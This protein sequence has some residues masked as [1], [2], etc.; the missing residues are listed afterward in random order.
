[1]DELI[2]KSNLKIVVEALMLLMDK[3]SQSMAEQDTKIEELRD[4]IGSP[5]QYVEQELTDAQKVQTRKNLDLY[6][7]RTTE[8]TWDGVIDGLDC[9]GDERDGYYRISS[10][11]IPRT[12][13]DGYAVE[14]INVDG[15]VQTTVCT[16]R[17]LWGNDEVY[18]PVTFFVVTRDGARLSDITFPLKGIYFYRAAD[19]GV[20]GYV[21]K[22]YKEEKETIPEWALPDID[23]DALSVQV[24]NTDG[25]MTEHDLLYLERGI[26]IIGES[27]D[28][29]GWHNELR[30]IVTCKTIPYCPYYADYED[31]GGLLTPM[32]GGVD[33]NDK[34]QFEWALNPNREWMGI[35]KLGAG[36]RLG[37]QIQSINE[38]GEMTAAPELLVLDNG[39]YHIVEPMLVE[40]MKP[41]YEGQYES[42]EI[43][44]LIYIDNGTI[45]SFAHG[46]IFCDYNESNGRFD[47]MYPLDGCG[48]Y[49]YDE[50][51]QE[52]EQKQSTL[53]PNGGAQVGQIIQIAEVDEDGRP[54]AW[55][56]V[57]IPEPGNS[58]YVVGITTDPDTSANVADKTF[59]E[60]STEFVEN[61]NIVAT[62]RGA[63]YNCVYARADGILFVKTECFKASG[64]FNFSALFMAPNNTITSAGAGLQQ[65]TAGTGIS[66]NDDNVISVVGG[67]TGGGASA[68]YSGVRQDGENDNTAIARITGV[69]EKHSGDICI[70]RTLIAGTKYSYMAY[71]YDGTN[72]AAMDGNVDA[73]HV[74]L[75]NDITCAGDYT[76]VGNITKTKTGT[77]TIPAA[78]KSVADVLTSIFTKELQPSVTQPSVTCTLTGAGAKEVGTEF[79]PTFSA[80]FDDGAYTYSADT[81]ATV[82]A[83][84]IT[85]S[86]GNTASASSGTLTKFTVADDTNYKVTAKATYSQGDIA[87]T[88]LGNNSNPIKRVAAGNKSGS[89]STVTGYRNAFAGT[90]TDKAETIDSAYIRSFAAQGAKVDGSVISIAVPV[91]AKRVLFA[92]PKKLGEVNSV[93]DV[94]GLGA[95][96]TSAFTKTTVIVQ[97]LNNYTGAEYYVYYTDYASANDKANTYTVTI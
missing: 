79:T 63:V 88:N 12:A 22:L 17:D 73:T 39:Y 50:M 34:L 4:K 58:T 96:I 18:G 33:G 42:I 78:G 95:N 5:V 48:Y 37:H 32:T 55:E 19:E 27:V 53:I 76:S 61:K 49:E 77:T 52:L 92:Y 16:S 2:K 43:T 46:A 97:G 90:K 35:Y 47:S 11:V 86:N 65:L 72:W 59:A 66:I 7:K 23:M 87:K 38:D 69:G 14:T 44:G 83:W 74:I 40:F 84:E 10:D 3:N 60:I 1:M 57:D 56:A 29:A 21:S 28:I 70:I 93:L 62:F 91:G 67:G 94:N 26:Y 24:I 15:E 75:Q 30:E 31:G 64:K 71:V 82:S 51:L 20:E 8:Y 36:Q 80:S 68:V 41:R 6:W 45:T 85:D 25:S 89:S 54:I 13:L 81:G 9:V